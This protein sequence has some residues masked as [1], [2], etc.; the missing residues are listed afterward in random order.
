[1]DA[2]K[3]VDGLADV[4]ATLRNVERVEVLLFLQMGRSKW[5]KLD[6]SYA[7]LDTPLPTPSKSPMG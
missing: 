2:P 5:E 1:M 4:V 3:K 7:L 6:Q